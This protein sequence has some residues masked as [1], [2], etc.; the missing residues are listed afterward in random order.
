MLRIDY[1]CN[2]VAHD[3][4]VAPLKQYDFKSLNMKSV[5]P[6]SY[7]HV[8]SILLTYPN[9][10]A[11]KIQPVSPTFF[12]ALYTYIPV[13]YFNSLHGSFQACT[14]SGEFKFTSFSCVSSTL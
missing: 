4:P 2:L 12:M 11:A 5:D 7:I 13:L 3:S 10:Q 6:S 1:K 8:L 9:R 14:L